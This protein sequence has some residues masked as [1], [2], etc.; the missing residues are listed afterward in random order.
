MNYNKLQ[1]SAISSNVNDAIV[2]YG[3]RLLDCAPSY[4][5]QTE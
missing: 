2:E 5:N 4:R 3:H 1:V